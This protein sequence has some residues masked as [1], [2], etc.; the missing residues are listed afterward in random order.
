MRHHAG[1]FD[2]LIAASKLAAR[3]QCLFLVPDVS[4]KFDANAVML[5]DGKVKLGYV[6]AGEA[7]GVKKILDK[8]TKERGQDQVIV[9]TV[10]PVKREGDF[11]WSTSITVK[12]VGFVY[13][14]VARKHAQG[15]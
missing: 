4:N 3:D 12:G 6:A 7:L 2:K 10:P 5:H 9:V 1:S 8:L 15:V 14:R 11:A 13:E